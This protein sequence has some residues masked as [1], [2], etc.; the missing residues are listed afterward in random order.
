MEQKK[1]E[2]EQIKQQSNNDFW[3]KELKERQEIKKKSREFRKIVDTVKKDMLE[4]IEKTS[5]CRENSMNNE[6]AQLESA[7]ES[8][9]AEQIKAVLKNLS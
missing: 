1:S 5:R 9:D 6:M 3:M 8:N 4:Q 7:L 2:N